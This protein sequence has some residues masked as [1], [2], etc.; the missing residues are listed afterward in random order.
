MSTR[1]VLSYGLNRGA[2][3][4]APGGD[5]TGISRAAMPLMLAQELRNMD[6]SFSVLFSCRTKGTVRSY[7]PYPTELPHLRE[8]C[9][10]DPS[11]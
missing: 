4:S 2:G 6:D 8:I 9:A 7:I 11:A 1:A 10:L 3:S 5:S